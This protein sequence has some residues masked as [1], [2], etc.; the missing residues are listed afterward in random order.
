MCRLGYDSFISVKEKLGK[1]LLDRKEIV[2]G[3]VGKL[4]VRIVELGADSK[5]T[6]SLDNK[7]N[8][9]GRNGLKTVCKL[10]PVPAAGKEEENKAGEGAE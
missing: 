4:I 10:F 1:C 6:L 3:G 8:F 2:G 7:S 9:H 5:P